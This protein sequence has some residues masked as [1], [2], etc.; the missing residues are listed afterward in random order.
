M[1]TPCIELRLSNTQSATLRFTVNTDFRPKKRRNE[2]FA[3]GNDAICMRQMKVH[4]KRQNYERQKF[5][6]H[7]YMRQTRTM[8]C[9]Y[10]RGP[11]RSIWNE[12]WGSRLTFCFQNSTYTK[13][14]HIEEVRYEVFTAVLRNVGILQFTV[15]QLRRTRLR[16]QIKS[17]Y[18]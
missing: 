16:V 10:T 9:F 11:C 1:P 5:E 14:I 6:T 3:S 15:S 4:V 18:T 2:D 12:N 13:I 8:S 17:F 7:V